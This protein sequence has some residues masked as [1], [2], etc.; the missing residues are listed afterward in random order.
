MSASIFIANRGAWGI[1][2][3]SYIIYDPDGDP[4]TLA[5][6]RILSGHPF[7]PAFEGEPGLGGS[8][9]I[10]VEFDNTN[11]RDTLDTDYDGINDATVASRNYTLIS[12]SPIYG[13][14]AATWNAMVGFAESLIGIDNDP[15]TDPDGRL[16]TD[17][18][19]EIFGPNSNSVIASILSAVGLDLD[20]NKPSGLFTADFVGSDELLSSAENLICTLLYYQGL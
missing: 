11:S 13:S 17:F 8:I 20:L 10:E 2:F 12:A 9:V 4:E 14:I 3:H 7:N 5:G 16:V 6:Q 1:E 18:E 15:A 19:Y